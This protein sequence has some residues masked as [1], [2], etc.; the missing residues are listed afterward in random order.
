MGDGIND[1]PALHAAD[2][3]I[4]VDSAVD[5]AFKEAADFVPGLNQTWMCC[6]A[7]SSK[8]DPRFANTLV[9]SDHHQRQPRATC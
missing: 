2:V 9:H 8:D 7:E 5:V 4:F 3:S 6:V 1:A